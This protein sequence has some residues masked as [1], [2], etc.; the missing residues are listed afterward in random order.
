MPLRDINIAVSIRIGLI[1]YV[2]HL[3]ITDYLRDFG[4]YLFESHGD[5]FFSKAAIVILVELFEN[6]ICLLLF[7]LRQHRLLASHVAK[8]NPFELVFVSH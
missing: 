5:I 7:S 4:I 1:D 6:N 8:H 3:F 2:S